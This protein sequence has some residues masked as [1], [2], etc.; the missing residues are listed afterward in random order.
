M[1]RDRKKIAVCS[2]RAELWFIP[3]HLLPPILFLIPISY[4]IDE[5]QCK[6]P[7]LDTGQS[8]TAEISSKT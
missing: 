3:T 2:N 4:L 7:I 6:S 5:K 1:E 8:G